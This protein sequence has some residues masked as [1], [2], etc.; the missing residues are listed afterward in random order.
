MFYNL[1][2][3]LL[4]PK[5]MRMGHQFIVFSSLLDNYL[6]KVFSHELATYQGKKG[7]E[8]PNNY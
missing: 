1:Y 4:T 2:T 7:K 3:A 8:I 6:G 5:T